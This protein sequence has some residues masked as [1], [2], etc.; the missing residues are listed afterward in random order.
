MIDMGPDPLTGKRRQQAKSGFDSERDAWDALAEAN[1]D[2]RT[3]TYVRTSR[4]TVSEFLNEWLTTIQMAVKP[5]TFANYSTYAKAYIIPLIG[6]RKLQNFRIS[7]R[8][9]STPCIDSYL[10][11]VDAAAPPIMSCTHGGEQKPRL[12]AQSVRS[13]LQGKPRSPTPQRPTLSAAT[14]LAGY[15]QRTRPA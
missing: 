1:A 2:L 5:T 3:N 8:K 15:P 13:T 9:P 7:N 12:V 6:D 14:E 4:S 10:R 11:P